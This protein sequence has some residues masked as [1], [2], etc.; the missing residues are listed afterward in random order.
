VA[1]MF[2][3]SKYPEKGDLEKGYCTCDSAPLLFV[4]IL[5]SLTKN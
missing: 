4:R 1:I 5:K 2:L 3:F